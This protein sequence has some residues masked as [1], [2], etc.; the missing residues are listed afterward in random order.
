MFSSQQQSVTDSAAVY[1]FEDTAQAV[2]VR[3]PTTPREVLRLLPADATP[4]QQDSAIQAMLD[5]PP[6]VISSR[7]DTL[8]LPGLEGSPAKVDLSRYS[9][10]DNFFSGFEF[11]HPELRVTQIG[12]AAEP[13][14]YRLR[15]DDFVT[16]ALLVSFFLVALFIVRSSHILLEKIKDFFYVRGNDDNMP[17]VNTDSELRNQA[18]LVI[19]TSFVIA[20][21]FFDY[22]QQALTHVFNSVSPY[23]LLGT[24]AGI[25]L[26][27]FAAKMLAYHFVNWV[28]FE[29]RQR[30]KWME[31]YVLTVMMTGLASFPLVLLL[32]Y[33][34]LPF[35][36]AG[37][38]F[39]IIVGLSKLLLFVKCKQIFFNLT[40]SIFH[41]FLYFCTLEL[42]PMLL[43][44]R[45]LVYC[46]EILVVNI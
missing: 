20:I 44:W 31:S 45:I 38:A 16:G 6:A 10:K 11:F 35:R 39:I 5:I 41:L 21:L 2:V 46:N 4:A 32:V 40:Y 24:D 34:D 9:Y 36:V 17:A 30:R 23:I 1:S 18:L 12:M 43:L 25:C 3:K 19:H 42:I 37:T 14:P 33:F 28:F 7:P 29:K 13:M 8:N 22:T 27:Y 15:D 26:L